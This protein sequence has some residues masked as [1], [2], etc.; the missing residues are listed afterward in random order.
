[1]YKVDQLRNA[2]A[3][4]CDQLPARFLHKLVVSMRRICTELVQVNGVIHTIEK[5]V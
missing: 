5:D 3:Q 1:M 2:I 4:E